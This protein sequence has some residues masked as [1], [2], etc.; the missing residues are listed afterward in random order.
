MARGG[1]SVCFINKCAADLPG[2]S[3]VVYPPPIDNCSFLSSQPLTPPPQSARQLVRQSVE[4][5]P[6]RDQETFFR[7]RN[8]SSCLNSN[9]RARVSLLYQ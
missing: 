4:G 8:R 9:V 1:L 5:R 3:L 2:L 7:A 6:S